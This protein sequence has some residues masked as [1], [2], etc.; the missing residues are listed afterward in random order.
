MKE[1]GSANYFLF[2]GS[3]DIVIGNKHL[4]NLGICGSTSNDSSSE[5]ELIEN[6]HQ[7]PPMQGASTF[8]LPEKV[9]EVFGSLHI[10]L[11]SK[12]LKKQGY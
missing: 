12:I 11:V 4:A 9:G 2:R 1:L 3:P 5:D 10:L 6:S 7:R 8:E